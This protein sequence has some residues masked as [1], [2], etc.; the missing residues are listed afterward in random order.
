MAAIS[1]AKREK[2]A[3]A[4]D[5]LPDKNRTATGTRLSAFSR[6]CVWLGYVQKPYHTSSSLLQRH[7]S[8]P[9]K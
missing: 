2:P 4:A 3:L 1:Q 8:K 5:F 7:S 6:F 9:L